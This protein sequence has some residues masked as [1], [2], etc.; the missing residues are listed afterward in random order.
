MEKA[1]RYIEVVGVSPKSFEDAL[2]EAIEEANN[3][4]KGKLRWFEVKEQ[5]GRIE[6]GKIVEF[7]ATLKIGYTV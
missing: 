5:R 7:Q 2:K 3:I 1:Y 6:G 4:V